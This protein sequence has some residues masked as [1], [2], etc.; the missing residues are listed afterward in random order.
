MKRKCYRTFTKSYIFH[1]CSFE[2]FKAVYMQINEL[3]TENFR[4][5]YEYNSANFLKLFI[6]LFLLENRLDL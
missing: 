1:A 3:S 5:V 6:V 2:A 4:K